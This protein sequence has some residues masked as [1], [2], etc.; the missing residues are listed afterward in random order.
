MQKYSYIDLPNMLD[1]HGS[2]DTV[3]E[4]YTIFLAE[5][6]NYIK[7]IQQFVA[8][9]DM[10]KLYNL[11][12]KLHGS[13]CYCFVPK[14][15][16]LAAKTEM[17]ACQRIIKPTEITELIQVLNITAQELQTLLEKDNDT[18]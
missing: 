4:L 9:K 14:L 5:I 11:L 18:I 8:Q 16:E 13:C 12:H 7:L 17:Q 2:A 10:E 1:V 6:P 3:K 15:K